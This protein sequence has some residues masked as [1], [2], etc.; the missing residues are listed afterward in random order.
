MLF[1]IVMVVL[2]LVVAFFHYTQGLFSATISASAGLSPR[3]A[4]RPPA[5][6]QRRWLLPLRL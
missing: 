6:H 1:G 3:S 2:I 5:W 4:G